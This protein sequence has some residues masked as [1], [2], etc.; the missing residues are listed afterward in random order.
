MVYYCYPAADIPKTQS[1][2]TSGATPTEVAEVTITPSPSGTEQTITD[3]PMT[4]DTKPTTEA[5]MPLKEAQQIPSDGTHTEQEPMEE[6]ASTDGIYILPLAAF[7]YN[8]EKGITCAYH[9][10]FFT[11]VLFD[12]PFINVYHCSC[13]YSTLS[14]YFM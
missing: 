10:V 4:E 8:N 5:N 13:H 2:S 6:E 1:E 12:K 7:V 3:A 9:Q 14:G 11:M